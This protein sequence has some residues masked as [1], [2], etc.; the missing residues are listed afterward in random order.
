[1]RLRAWA[2]RRATDYHDPITGDLLS[3][4]D[5]V[6]LVA[7]SVIRRWSFIGAV[8]VI[9]A[10]WWTWP[11]A[12]G[13]RSGAPLHWNLLA[14]LMALVI[15]SVVGIGMFSS[16]R[17]DAVIL[18]QVRANEDVAREALARVEAIEANHDETLRLLSRLE[19]EHG[20]T[21]AMIREAVCADA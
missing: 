10:A 16:G 4:S 18:R 19:T 12:F 7:Q 6:S 17:R 20:E 11:A 15:E 2:L 1:V 8:I 21:L 14:S 5:Q 9:T 13:D 3:V